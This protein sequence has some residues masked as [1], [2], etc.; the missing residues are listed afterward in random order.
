M[1][2]ILFIALSLALVEYFSSQI[3]VRQSPHGP[4]S[5]QREQAIVS[6]V[7]V[8][9]LGGVLVLTRPEGLLLAGMVILG[10]LFF[11]RA[12]DRSQLLDRLVPTGLS[13]AALAGAL[14]PYLVFN[15]RTSGSIFPNTFYAKQVEYLVDWPLP[16]RFW[17][18]FVPTLAGAQVLLLPGFGY[19]AYLLIRRRAWPALLPLTWWFALLAA[20]AL[21]LPVNYQH[22]RYVMPTVP[23]VILYGVWGTAALLRPHS[24]SLLVRVLSRGTL[25]AVALLVLLFW[26]R[27]AM[28]YSDDVAFIEGE[29]VAMSRWIEENLTWLSLC[30]I[31]VLWAI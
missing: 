23:W 2:T 20:Y 10:L 1:E 12:A 24:P 3:A 6:A 25:P 31:L 4:T 8:G 19:A 15:L 13:L 27:G 21:R 18:V 16:V 9:L 30:T 28:A 22:G 7:G 26:G 5:L 17:R 11:P 14:V 29:M